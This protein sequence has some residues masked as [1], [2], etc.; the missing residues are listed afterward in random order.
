MSYKVCPKCQSE[1][2]WSRHYGRISSEKPSLFGSNELLDLAMICI[3]CGFVEFYL[4][5]ETLKKL[6]K[7]GMGKRDF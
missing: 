3:N 7:E 5:Q 4:D 1:M 6:K 2:A